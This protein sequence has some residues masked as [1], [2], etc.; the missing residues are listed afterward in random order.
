M[1][2]EELTAGQ[3][4]EGVGA[5]FQVVGRQE[6]HVAE[7]IFAQALPQLQQLLSTRPLPLLLPLIKKR[8][9][10]QILYPFVMLAVKGDYIIVVNCLAL[11]ENALFLTG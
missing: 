3:G 9:G 6:L 7:G 8:S 10:R 5:F 1:A 4:L 11:L 2:G